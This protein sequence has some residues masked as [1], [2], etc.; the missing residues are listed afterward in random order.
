MSKKDNS[1]I[2]KQFVFTT[3]SI[4]E[5]ME[6]QSQGFA[7]PRY[8]NPWFKNQTG[9]RRTGCVYGWTQAEIDEFTKCALDIQYFAN[10]YCHIKSEDGQI[11]QMKLRDYQYKVLDMYTKNR[12]VINMSSRQTGKCFLMTTI[13]KILNNNIEIKIP[14]FKLLFNFKKNKNIYDYIKYS[15]YWIY[16]KL[17]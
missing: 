8:M 10:T 5:V 6:K 9:V 16:W 17:N 4:N 7:I 15:I 2:E 13:V 14:V 12:F 11:R 3:D 1:P